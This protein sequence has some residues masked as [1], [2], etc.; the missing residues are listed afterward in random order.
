MNYAEAFYGTT[1]LMKASENGYLEIFREL[2]KRGANVNAARPDGATSLIMASQNGHLEIARELCARGANVNAS[3]TDNGATALISA[4]YQ[5]HLEVAR[6]LL[7]KGA[8]KSPIDS[9]GYTAFSAAT[10][11]HKAALQALLKL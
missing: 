5:G 1:P 11:P 10:G 7:Q 3:R 8:D 4:S 9:F 2:C 6:L